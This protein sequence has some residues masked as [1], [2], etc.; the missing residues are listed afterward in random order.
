MNTLQNSFASLYLAQKYESFEGHHL[1]GI[2]TTTQYAG[3][4]YERF[5]NNKFSINKTPNSIV[6]KKKNK[7]Q[8]SLISRNKTNTTF[9]GIIYREY[10]L[11]GCYYVESLRKRKNKRDF[12]IIDKEKNDEMMFMLLIKET[13]WEDFNTILEKYIHG[14]YDKLIQELG[15]QLKPLGGEENNEGR[16]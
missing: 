6:K 5:L 9:N 10:K 7:L 13:N 8:L 16:V 2:Y 12:F 1:K 15:R 11:G 14:D 3:D 4:I